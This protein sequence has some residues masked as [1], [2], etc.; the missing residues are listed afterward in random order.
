MTKESAK[1]TIDKDD[2]TI[3]KYRVIGPISNLKEFSDEFNCPLGT[4]MN[5][6]NKCEVW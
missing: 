3:S 1:V 4:T 6:I 5:P 2:H